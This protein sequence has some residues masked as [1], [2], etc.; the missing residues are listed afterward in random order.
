MSNENR[1]HTTWSTRLRS[2]R[3]ASGMSQRTLG[4]AAG[5]D[6]SIASTRI[7]RYEL[8]VHEPAYNIACKLAASLKIPVAYLY[9]NDESLAVFILAF[10]RASEKSRQI[11]INVLSSD[12][13]D[14]LE[15]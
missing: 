13:T 10:N 7:N 4:I 15:V 1:S 9:C 5:L 2:A 6:P 3:L 8:G 12:G 14:S 11:C